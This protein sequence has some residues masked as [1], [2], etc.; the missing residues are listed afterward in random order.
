MIF[1][2]KAPLLAVLGTALGTWLVA[3]ALSELAERLRL[4]RASSG[5]SWRRARHLPRA[6]YGMTIAHAGAGI[7]ILGIIVSVTWETEHLQVVRVGD[8]VPIGGYEF[9]SAESRT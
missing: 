4:F 8:T 9:T 3:A 2:A 6:A 7:V 1:A 5:E